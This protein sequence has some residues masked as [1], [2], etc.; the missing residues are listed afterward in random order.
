MGSIRFCILG[1]LQIPLPSPSNPHQKFLLT[2]I[3]VLDAVVCLNFQATNVDMP[4]RRSPNHIPSESE[5]IVTILAETC[6]AGSIRRTLSADMS[7]KKWLHQNGFFSPIKKIVSSQQIAPNQDQVWSSI[8]ADKDTNDQPPQTT[9]VWGLIL[10][11]KSDTSPPYIP[12]M[13]KRST[14]SLSDKSLEVCTESLGSETGSDCFSCPT[15]AD[16]QDTDD[17]ILSQR[18]EGDPFADLHVV[19]YKNSPPRPF[20]PPLPSIAAGASLQ[21]QSHRQNGRLVLEAVSVAPRN[22]FHARRHDGRLLLTLEHA[23]EAEEEEEEETA[24]QLKSGGGKEESLVEKNLSLPSGMISVHK[25]G[26]VMKKLMAVG[27]INPKWAN[28]VAARDG[29]EI[30]P[31]SLPPRPR[32][33][34]LSF[35]DYEYFWRSEPGF[36]ISRS[37]QEPNRTEKTERISSKMN[38][39]LVMYMRGCKEKRRSLIWE[40]P[41][42]IATS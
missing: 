12:P 16:D 35:N 11:Q 10:T 25:S 40:K 6:K 18:N 24:V 9:G 3:L 23:P 5:G 15:D 42:C 31:Q 29:G 4:A 30:S 37:V 13:L 27:N 38:Q 2:T 33:G 14:S 17:Q 8:Q 21:M 28:D 32:A 19:K 22:V 36:M 7:S 41:Y 39:E 26:L 34:R 1:S 20:P